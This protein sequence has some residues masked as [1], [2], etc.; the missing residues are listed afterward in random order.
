MTR[1]RKDQLALND[2]IHILHKAKENIDTVMELG[3]DRGG[4]LRLWDDIFKP[5]EII[6][7]DNVIEAVDRELVD[8]LRADVRLEYFDQRDPEDIQR[9]SEKLC[10]WVDNVDLIIDD[11]CHD[12]VAIEN[13]LLVFWDFLVPGGLYVVEDWQASYGIDFARKAPELF[14]DLP[15]AV[16]MI[17]RPSMIVFVKGEHV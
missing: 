17:V 12:A 7:L 14:L 2:Y 13:S 4:S 16:E 11:C 10:E 8:G 9:V 3:V 1:H 5:V 15:G 6:G